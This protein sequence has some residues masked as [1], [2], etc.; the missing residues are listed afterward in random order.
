[1]CNENL[2]YGYIPQDGGGYEN[3]ADVLGCTV[4]VPYAQI[5]AS[6]VIQVREA[7]IC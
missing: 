2:I 7:K 1:M 6:R 5:M 3:S 4:T